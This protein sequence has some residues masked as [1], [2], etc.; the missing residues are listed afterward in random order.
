MWVMTSYG[1]FMPSMRPADHTPKDDDR[2][3]Q[4]RARRRVELQ[5]LC[6]V[7]P[8]LGFTS[9]DIEYT[10]FTD[11]E[12]RI[13]CTRA[14]LA[15][16]LHDEGAAIDY[17]KF[18]DTTKRWNDEKLHTAYIKIWGLLYEMFSTNKMFS[19]RPSRRRGK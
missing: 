7:H 11:Y 10:D 18:K 15:L 17:V 13:Y 5:R 2:I 14:Q 19:P 12:Y 8:T 9:S 6:K 16:W 3:M 1:I 4:I